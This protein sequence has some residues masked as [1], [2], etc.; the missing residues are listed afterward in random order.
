MVWV[1]KLNYITMFQFLSVEG[2][3]WCGFRNNI[4]IRMYTFDNLRI[5]DLRKLLAY[6]VMTFHKSTDVKVKALYFDDADYIPDCLDPKDNEYENYLYADVEC[7]GTTH[8]WIFVWNT[9][10]E[11]FNTMMDLDQ[12]WQSDKE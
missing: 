9:A 4:I 8:R 5:G 6:E 1:Q 7:N 2:P 3:T 10:D 11:D 12:N